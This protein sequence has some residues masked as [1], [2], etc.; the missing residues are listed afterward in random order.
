MRKGN[1]RGE[2]MERKRGEKICIFMTYSTGGGGGVGGKG[3][4]KIYKITVGKDK[5]RENTCEVSKKLWEK[6][7]NYG[8]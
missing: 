8:E 3:I 1:S 2:Q 7:K 6:K 5:N 4:K